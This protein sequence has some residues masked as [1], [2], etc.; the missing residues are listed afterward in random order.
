MPKA[1]KRLDPDVLLRE[2]DSIRSLA[3]S[4]V[5]DESVAD[6]L[7]QETVLA[8]LTPGK[9]PQG[10]L[11][12][13]LRKVL[14]Y[15]LCAEQRGDRRRKRREEKTAR[16]EALPSPEAAVERAEIV[17]KLTLAVFDLKEPFRTT[18]ILR[19]F[20]EL[21]P[22]EI[23]VQ[24]AVRPSTVRSR[25]K[26]GLDTLRTRLDA[27]HGGR[28][29]WV[30]AVIALLGAR[31]RAMDI[32]A[33]RS[34]ADSGGALS[35]GATLLRTSLGVSCLLAVV[36]LVV[37]SPH[38]DHAQVLDLPLLDKALAAPL[39]PPTSVQETTTMID[40][41]TAKGEPQMASGNITRVAAF[42]S[43]VAL[44]TPVQPTEFLRGD[45]N[46]DGKVSLADA[47]YVE[48]FL[49]LL[50]E[51]PHCLN[52]ADAN[53]D[54]R[55]MVSDAI[56]IFNTFSRG[57]VI[58]PPFPD[59]GSDPTANGDLGVDCQAYGDGDPL[60]SQGAALKVLEAISPGGGNP[61]AVITIAMS[62]PRSIAG[63]RGTIRLEGIIA[64]FSGRTD[65]KVPEVGLPDDLTGTVV[66]TNFAADFSFVRVSATELQFGFW[67]APPWVREPVEAG[68]DVPLIEI[69]VC[70]AAGVRAG[71]YPI[72]LEFGELVDADTGRTVEPSLVSGTLSVLDDVVDGL[73][74]KGKGP[75]DCPPP[76]GNTEEATGQM[77][78][79]EVA[80]LPG[81]SAFVPLTMVSTN[82]IAAY[83]F[84]VDFDE[85]L[86]EAIDAQFVYEKPDGS[87]YDYQF[88]GINTSNDIPGSGGV[89]EGYIVGAAVFNRVDNCNNIPANVET[90]ACWLDFNVKPGVQKGSTPLRF[91]DGI[92]GQSHPAGQNFQ[93]LVFDQTLTIDG[94]ARLTLTD[95]WVHITTAAA[96]FRRGDSNGDGTF[97]ISDPIRTL[98]ALFLGD[99]QPLCRDALDSNDDSKVDIS[100][101]L[102]ALQR[103]FLGGS[104]PPAPGL[105]EC[106]LDPTPDALG[107]CAYDESSC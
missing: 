51:G 15:R 67:R 1:H 52:A 61:H 88:L 58:P 56:L 46:G 45:A 23:A 33:R 11:K 27:K 68:E 22:N 53:D 35:L 49:W 4:L 71:E 30:L 55:V 26:R 34:C 96:R 2:V 8:A 83:G 21:E 103:L 99:V 73:G 100:D 92:E 104:P 65:P 94:S 13:W 18:V 28:A 42:A 32:A 81:E 87:P 102:F 38:R 29:A 24:L 31:A 106:G 16:G 10:D 86:L 91:I 72:P 69:P 48:R 37:G 12:A 79:A 76:S 6:D 78:L 14:K 41:G 39:T 19:Y 75:V 89:D 95:G 66:E 9:S 20:E 93:R 57:A 90:E 74:C 101:S 3:R 40:A 107:P 97:N 64:D 7:V 17:R 70:L 44:P 47:H 77:M 60:P 80:A 43:I 98:G 5:F 84:S 50:G 59:T 82:D 36:V 63:Y 25:L 105:E 54:G 62:S 85:E